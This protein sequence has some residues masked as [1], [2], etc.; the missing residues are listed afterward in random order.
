MVGDLAYVAYDN[1]GL[2]LVDVSDPGNPVWV[3]YYDTAGL[4]VAIAESGGHAYLADYYGGLYILRAAELS[5]N[6]FL[7]LIARGY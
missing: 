2:L 1:F 6:L 7:P 4:G 5:H 3:G